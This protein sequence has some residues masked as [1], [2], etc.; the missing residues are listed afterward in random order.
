LIFS[1]ILLDLRRIIVLYIPEQDIPRFLRP[2]SGFWDPKSSPS[3]KNPSPGPI[4]NKKAGLRALPT[5]KIVTVIK[6]NIKK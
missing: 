3:F 6:K 1:N 2:S 5:E 4:K